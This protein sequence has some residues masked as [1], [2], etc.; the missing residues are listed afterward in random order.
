MNSRI[1]N[2]E[3]GQSLV[4]IAIT[5]VGLIAMTALVIDG[6][7]AYTNRRMAQAAADAGALAGAYELC[8]GASSAAAITAAETLAMD[9]VNGATSATAT[10]SGKEVTVVTAIQQNSFFAQILNINQIDVQASATADCFVPVTATGDV[11]PFAWLCSEPAVGSTSND[12]D[13]MALNWDSEFLIIRDGGPE[14]TIAYSLSS[15]I[16]SA[17]G[18]DFTSQV[19]ENYLYIIMDSDSTDSQFGGVHSM[20][21]G[22]RN[23]LDLDGGGGGANDLKDWVVN[24]VSF[25]INA[26]TWYPGKPGMMQ[27]VFSKV[28]DQVDAGKHLL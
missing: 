27:T 14:I 19:V 17:H 23:W 21:Q 22:N 4:L 18:V 3:K 16:N 12:C 13:W 15:P 28:G 20:G 6:G 7:Q 8:S 1:K 5:M 9:A 2:L 11:L 26:H 10:I 24:G 25:D